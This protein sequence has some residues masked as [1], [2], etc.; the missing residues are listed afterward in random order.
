MKFSFA[1]DT[2]K[3]PEL[4]PERQEN[5]NHLNEIGLEAIAAAGVGL[6]MMLALYMTPEEFK[7]LVAYS[8]KSFQQGVTNEFLKK[9]D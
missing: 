3:P 9:M 4:Q 8:R 7:L 5:R 2:E 1:L 6:L